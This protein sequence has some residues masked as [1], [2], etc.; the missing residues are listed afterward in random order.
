MEIFKVENLS[1]AYPESGE[2]AI[3]GLSFTINDGEFITLCGKSGCGKTTLLRLLKSSLSPEGKTSGSIIYLGRNLRE[4]SPREDAQNIGFVFQNPEFQLCCDK[5]WH[6]IA[7][8]LESLGLPEDEIRLRVS[9]TSSFFGISDLFHKK[10]SE[11]SGGQKQLVCLASVMVMKPKVLILDEPTS[12]LDPISAKHFIEAVKR[13]NTEMGVTVIM[14]EQ[15]LNEVLPISDR[16]V[17]MDDGRIFAD[18]SVSAVA[19]T[20]FEERHEM[21]SAFPPQMRIYAS[22]ENGSDYPISVKD[23]KT[24]LTE[25]SQNHTL[26][27]E[28][29]KAD[30]QPDTTKKAVSLF[31]VHFRYEKN[32][33]DVLKGISLTAYKGEILSILGSNGVGKSTL[34]SVVLGIRKGYCGKVKTDGRISY[35]PQDVTSLF[36]KDTV[37]TDLFE[38]TRNENAVMKTAELCDIL[39]L[40]DKHPYDL[41]GG[42]KQRAALCKVLLT[43]PEILLLD[44]PTKGMDAHFKESFGKLLHK[45]KNDGITIINVSHDIEFCASFSD[46]C[47]LMFDGKI[48]S[49]V[50]PK[51]FFT[52]M[53]YYT[54]DTVRMA[55]NILPT[56]VTVNDAISALGG[57]NFESEKNDSDNSDGDKLPPI[58]KKEK[59]SKGFTLKSLL[60]LIFVLLAVPFTVYFGIKHLSDRQYYLV[61]GIVIAEILLPF[62]LMFERRKPKAREIV[63]LSVLSAICVAGR[64]IFFMVPQFKPMAAIIIISGACLG[65]ESGMIVGAVSAF[66][67]NLFFGQGP[68]TVW[69]MTA[70][71]LIGLVSGLVFDSCKVKKSKTALCIFGFFAT[72]LIYGGILNPASVLMMNPEPSAKLLLSSF[73]AGFPFDLIH[74]LSTVVFLFVLAEAF[75]GKI[76]RVKIKYGLMTD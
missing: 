74:S 16:V 39:N 9:E 14:S 67:S 6:E 13:V 63:T 46:R 49:V 32:S 2:N 33:G 68:W 23:G 73:V 38:I 61:S 47:A 75:V 3:S 60:P 59:D 21:F 53:N 72:F 51:S 44:E 31:E 8:G 71:A 65:Y 10:V 22:I 1:F 17:V 4:L 7:F 37:R 12:S 26:Y 52:K 50:T 36:V 5:V 69:Q 41:S 54:T 40:L 15:R 58:S 35:M 29:I 27:P 34:L 45:L 55:N 62:L 24:W 11:L 28:R 18:G 30:T 56:A 48:S 25:Y 57:K 70:F 64:S 76:E 42:E 66:V 20:L 19:N 43:N